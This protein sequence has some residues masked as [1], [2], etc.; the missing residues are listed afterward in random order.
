MKLFIVVNTS[1]K[2]KVGLLLS[3]KSKQREREGKPY[4]MIRV[5]REVKGRGEDK[6][7]K[8]GPEMLW[9]P[10][11]VNELFKYH[12]RSN[13]ENERVLGKKVAWVYPGVWNTMMVLEYR[14][15]CSKP[16]SGGR[17]T[18]CETTTMVQT[19]QGTPSRMVEMKVEIKRHL[20]IKLTRPG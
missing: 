3:R 5:K 6:G 1:S 7:Q 14:I 17:D 8:T 19:R 4:G 15:D 13:V 16:E 9:R 10:L 20:E 11:H 18:S 2:W 12:P